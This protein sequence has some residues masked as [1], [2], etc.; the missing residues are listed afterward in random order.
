ME[1]RSRAST[2]HATRPR[3]QRGFAYVYTAMAFVPLAGVLAFGIQ[4]AQLTSTQAALQDYVDARAISAI[5]DRFGDHTEFVD[6]GSYLPGQTAAYEDPICGGWRPGERKFDQQSPCRKS[7]G[8]PAHRFAHTIS[9]PLVAAPLLKMIGAAEQAELTAEATSFIPRRHI[10][11]VQDVSG[12]LGEI[13]PSQQA[14]HRVLDTLLAQDLPGDDVG[15]LSF[16]DDATELVGLQPLTAGETALRE[17]IDDLEII[18]STNTAAAIEL[19]R[20]MAVPVPVPTYEAQ[21]MLVLITDGVP[22]DLD[23]AIEQAKITCDEDID[24]WGIG[25]GDS[26]DLDQLAD[27]ACDDDQVV[28][29]PHESDI[30]DAFVEILTRIPVRLAQ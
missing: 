27:M 7:L 26:L 5:K 30:R 28:P 21:P 23:A 6:V 12:S 25:V 13:G 1:H 20:Q 4:W 3:R 2:R 29:A 9:L 15:L 24:I 14:L 11:L 10:I 16:S 22:N 19:G 17:A 8:A 18:N